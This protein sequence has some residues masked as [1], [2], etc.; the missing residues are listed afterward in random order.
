MNGLHHLLTCKNQTGQ[1]IEKL[2]VRAD[3]QMDR[4]AITMATKKIHKLQISLVYG[5]CVYG[6]SKAM[7]GLDLLLVA[8]GM[9]SQTIELQES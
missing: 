2:S 7:P 1:W 8:S 5:L 3:G 4:Q 9:P 6:T